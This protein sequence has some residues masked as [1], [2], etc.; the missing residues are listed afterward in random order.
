MVSVQRVYVYVM[1]LLVKYRDNRETDRAGLKHRNIVFRIAQ[2]GADLY[3]SGS[4][5]QKLCIEFPVFYEKVFDVFY[6][7]LSL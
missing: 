3:V 4:V 2:D 7:S 1:F 5:F 6:P